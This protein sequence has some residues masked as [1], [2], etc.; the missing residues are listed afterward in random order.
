MSF[1]EMQLVVVTDYI[2]KKMTDFLF[3]KEN[4]FYTRNVLQKRP[5]E[6]PGLYK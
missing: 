3:G 5:Q 4:C 1:I 6:L 2:L